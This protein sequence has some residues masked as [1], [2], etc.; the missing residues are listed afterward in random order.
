[1]SP[2][3]RSPNT[4]SIRL[5]SGREKKKVHAC[6][7]CVVPI[8]PQNTLKIA[9]PCEMLISRGKATKTRSPQP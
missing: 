5:D 2:G 8:T 7:P 4:P 6:P 3:N 9:D 1:M